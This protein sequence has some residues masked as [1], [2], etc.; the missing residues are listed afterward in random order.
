MSA[1]VEVA[2][3][4]PAELAEGPLWDDREQVLRWVDIEVGELHRL[5]P[6]TGADHAVSLGLPVGAVALADNGGLVV[7]AGLGLAAYT[8]GALDWIAHV[9]R[10]RRVNDAKVDP[11][12]RLLL[13]TLGGEQQAGAAA[14]YRVDRG[15]VSLIT[16]AT[17]SNGLGWSP[18]GSLLYYV[19]TPLRR[20]DVFDY[21]VATGKCSARRTFVD[22]SAATGRPDGLTVDAEGGVWVA[23]S[24]GGAAV[25]RF[26]PDA[27]PD[28]A[29]ALPVPN[30]TSATFGGSNLR[31]LYVT[32][33]RVGGH[34]LAGCVFVVSDVGVTGMPTGRYAH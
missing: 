27:R 11:A 25:R 12:G 21:D 9:C 8:D 32:T 24:R 34:P 17:I 29:I 7:A 4:T 19:D 6:H 28:E 30:V 31:D 10:G 5:D 1:P 33:A 23:M 3:A 13:G 20:V 15:A 14:L 16:P 2:V 22:L 18:D 26:G